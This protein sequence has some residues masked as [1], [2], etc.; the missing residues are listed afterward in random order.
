M[1]ERP[2]KFFNFK[3]IYAYDNSHSSVELTSVSYGKFKFNLFL[4]L[5]EIIIISFMLWSR[6]RN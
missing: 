4:L 1:S 2:P 3:T 6:K 5:L